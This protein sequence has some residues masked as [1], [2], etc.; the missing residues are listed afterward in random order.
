MQALSLGVRFCSEVM[1]HLSESH[2]VYKHQMALMREQLNKE[3][4]AARDNQP[5]AS[6]F[7][8]IASYYP[9]RSSPYTLYAPSQHG[10]AM[11]ARPFAPPDPPDYRALAARTAIELE[12]LQERAK[13][14]ESLCAQMQEDLAF[15]KAKNE[16]MLPLLQEES[17]AR[18]NLELEL[19]E[20]KRLRTRAEAGFASLA[21]ENEEHVRR[22]GLQDEERRKA[23][24]MYFTAK[25][26]L[27]DH[28]LARGLRDPAA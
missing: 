20:E 11:S 4:E 18:A 5:P 14:L 8:R 23:W 27:E 6:E 9:P 12:D 2:P 22:L 17:A 26:R 21:A 3:A 15:E 13:R 16:E 25:Q 1:Q 24:R 28:G 19:Q 10:G 7:M